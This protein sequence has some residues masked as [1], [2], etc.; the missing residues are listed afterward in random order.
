MSDLHPIH[1]VTLLVALLAAVF[2]FIAMQA[3]FDAREEARTAGELA[4]IGEGVRPDVH[5]LHEALLRAGLIEDA[6]GRFDYLDEER[7]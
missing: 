5:E 2:S 6:T 4:S 3:A 1:A 7:P